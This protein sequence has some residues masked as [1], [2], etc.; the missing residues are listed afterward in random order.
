MRLLLSVTL[1][2]ALAATTA[3]TPGK[4]M[5]GCSSQPSGA[6]CCDGCTPTGNMPGTSCGPA[7]VSSYGCNM[8]CGSF[9]CCPLANVTDCGK[10]C[11]ID[12][13]CALGNCTSCTIH[14][15]PHGAD[16]VCAPPAPPSA[17]ATTKPSPPPVIFPQPIFH[18]PFNGGDDAAAPA[19]AP[20]PAAAAAAAATA[21]PAP[22]LQQ[23][24]EVLPEDGTQGWL[25]ADSDVS[26]VIGGGKT[27]RRALWIF[28]DTYITTYQQR[29]NQ[30][31]WKGMEMPHSTVG[32]VECR[33]S[34]TNSSQSVE[35]ECPHKPVFHWKKTAAGNAETFW[36]LPPDQT[37]AAVPVPLLWPVAGLAS[38][39][40]K[41]AIL[42]AQRILG[43]MNVQGTT[44]IVVDV[45]ADDPTTWAYSTTPV[46]SRN[47][48]FNCFS[49]ITWV[50]PEDVTDTGVY[51]FCHD[52]TLPKTEHA[53]TVLA[54]G[55]FAQ[56][57]Q[58]DWS[59]LSYWTTSGWTSEYDPAALQPLNLPSWE[60]TCR[61]SSQ[62]QLFYTFDV[63][64]SVGAG[65]EIS[66]WTAKEVTYE[67]TS[68]VV[69]KLPAPFS[70]GAPDES[71]LC[72]AAKEHPELAA[73]SSQDEDSVELV[74]S[75]ICNAFGN[76]TVEQSQLFQAGGMSLESTAEAPSGI[77][78][79]WF[80]FFRV[81][82][83]KQLMLK[84]DDELI[85]YTVSALK[86]PDG[87]S[88]RVVAAMDGR[89]AAVRERVGTFASNA[90][91]PTVTRTVRV[92]WG[93]TASPGSYVLHER[94]GTALLTVRRDDQAG[95]L[96]GIGRLLR[97]LRVEHCS[98]TARLPKHGLWEH[99]ASTALWPMRGHQVST[100]HHPSSL[101]TWPEFSR[102]VSDLAV[103]GT[104]QIEVA[105]I[106]PTVPNEPP[107]D[108][109][110]QFYIK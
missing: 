16:R 102:F 108:A 77:R 52:S 48:T 8:V 61:W 12:S 70:P 92:E 85:E 42:L 59:A 90:P 2:A 109:L 103:F 10:R 26:I 18:I 53:S 35:R 49:T 14:R 105:H 46:P 91:D 45:T 15:S 87:I 41:T 51:L 69:Y 107:L 40:G 4:C 73:Q 94:T 23:Q 38:R 37:D 95:L 64:P 88:E 28:A 67:W 7:R 71:W 100:A 101:K 96:S 25:G 29:A 82:A 1:R 31:L 81:A 57:A 11:S 97:E 98:A 24:F 106:V 63:N 76:A 62:L 44:A 86:L 80:R 75:Y 34:S 21:V 36:V 50:K 68:T 39:D 47:S 65:K 3:Q 19:A 27:G 56:L 110:G 55:D 33:G 89:L 93:S 13:E 20:A 74:F 99:N 60:T 22:D 79:Y 5:G 66:M 54:R 58:H 43:G 6:C 30:R 104:T 32:I 78:G 83:S 17:A 84:T 9:C 72:Y